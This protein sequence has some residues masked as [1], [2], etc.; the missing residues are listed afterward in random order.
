MTDMGTERWQK[1]LALFQKVELEYVFNR[2]H[3]LEEA[4]THSSFAHESGLSFFN[5]RLEFLG[6]AVLELVV[7]ESLYTA[8]AHEPEGVLTQKRA[9]LVCTSSLAECGK[10]IGLHE[11]IRLGKGLSNQGG[12]ANNSICADAL[13]AIFGAVFL[14]GGLDRARQVILKVMD[15]H[16]ITQGISPGTVQDPK[17]RL[18][19]QIQLEKGELPSYQ[20]V[21]EEGPSHSPTFIVEVWADGE[22]LGVGTGSSRKRA[23]RN[24]ASKALSDRENL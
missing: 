2:V 21:A 20:V 19:Q 9:S 4:L 17:T 14:D 12:R 18:Q 23:E 13:E 5:E 10:G 3:L 7:S 6:D 8:F 16:Q 22:R 11:L 24:A 1:T 15:L